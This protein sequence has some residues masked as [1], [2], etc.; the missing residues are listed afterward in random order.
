MHVRAW[1]VPRD[2]FVAGWNAAEADKKVKRLAGR[3]VLRWAVMARAAALRK[4]GV[5]LT[6]WGR[7]NGGA[8]N[9]ER[10]SGRQCEARPAVTQTASCRSRRKS[11]STQ[12]LYESL[13]SG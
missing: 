11:R 3:N 8:V 5:E 1:K 6:K 13:L 7:R 4:E 12:G 2:Q 10:F 9:A